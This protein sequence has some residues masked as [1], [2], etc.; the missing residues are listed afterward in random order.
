MTARPRRA[1]APLIL[2]AL[3]LTTLL[4]F[5]AVPLVSEPARAEM[6]SSSNHLVSMTA[7]GGNEEVL[8]VIDN[9]SEKLMVYKINNQASFDLM[10]SIDLPRLF[11]SARAQRT[12]D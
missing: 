1:D 9:R 3:L 11:Q 6:V 2:C 7:K 10:Q 12:G 4:A 5:V 8:V